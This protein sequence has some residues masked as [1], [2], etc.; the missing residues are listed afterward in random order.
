MVIAMLCEE[1]SMKD[2]VANLDDISILIGSMSPTIVEFFEN[3]FNET[4]FTKKIKN[5]DWKLG[6]PLKVFG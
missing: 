2:F 6:R 1:N 5:L 4:R 3:G